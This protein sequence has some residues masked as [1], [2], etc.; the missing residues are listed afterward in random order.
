MV[1]D[2]HLR[3]MRAQ[4]LGVSGMSVQLRRF[5]KVGRGKKQRK[6]E[7]CLQSKAN[8]VLGPDRETHPLHSS[9]ASATVLILE[10]GGLDPTVAIKPRRAQFEGFSLRLREPLS[11]FINPK[12]SYLWPSVVLRM[13]EVSV[14]RC[15]KGRVRVKV[16]YLVARLVRRQIPCG[17]G[18]HSARR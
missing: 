8:R 11:F 5:S 9:C 15:M 4:I 7:A 17:S 13:N 3:L 16:K 6:Q 14:D 1:L 10:N 12:R 18:G 2:A